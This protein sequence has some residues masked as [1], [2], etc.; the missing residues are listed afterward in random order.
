VSF[1]RLVDV[2][3]TSTIKRKNVHAAVEPFLKRSSDDV[4]V[5]IITVRKITAHVTRVEGWAYRKENRVGQQYN[6][7]G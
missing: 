3:L 5:L 1:S 7:E 6:D 2:L 4:V